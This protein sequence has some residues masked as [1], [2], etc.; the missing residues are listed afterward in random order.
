MGND[1][2]IGM[3]R[4]DALTKMGSGLVGLT[5][6]TGF[7]GVTP[8]EARIKGVPFRHLSAFDGRLLEAFGDVL[9]PGA[10]EAGIVHYVDDQLGRAV[11]LLFLKYMDYVGSFVD[12]YK[13]GLAALEQQSR[14]QYSGSFPELAP[15]Q[16]VSLVRGISQKNPESWT[17][18]PAPLFYF[19]VRNDAVDVY[20]GTPAGFAKLG[21]PYMPM[22]EPPKSQ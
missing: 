6:S 14:R 3:N 4:R 5:I 16:K 15:D 22:I 12:F 19:V 13:E 8:A 20:Y 1:Q 2:D 11:P 7:G 10:A 18:P 17:G 21:V 9:L